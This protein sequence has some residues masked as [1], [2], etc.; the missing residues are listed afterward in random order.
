MRGG[1]PRGVAGPSLT[2][3]VSVSIAWKT[4]GI[5]TVF[6]AYSQPDLPV[7]WARS[8]LDRATVADGRQRLTRSC[9]TIRENGSRTNCPTTQG[10]VAAM[11]RMFVCT[12]LASALLAG[13]AGAQEPAPLGGNDYHATA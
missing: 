9:G 1:N 10:G 4:V 13:R 5:I 7:V 11:K 6:A 2:L 12:V 3:R 8:V